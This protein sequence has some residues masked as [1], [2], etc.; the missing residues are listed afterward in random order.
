MSWLVLMVDES[1]SMGIVPKVD[2][3]AIS[4]GGD[5]PLSAIVATAINAWL[6]R[7]AAEFNIALV[8]YHTGEDGEPDIGVRW[9]G[10]LEGSNFV[11]APQ[12]KEA[13]LAIEQRT[14]SLPGAAPQTIDFKVW[15]H[16]AASGSQ[17][18]L[19]AWNWITEF[20]QRECT[21][22]AEVV[23]VNIHAGLSSDGNPVRVIQ[24]FAAAGEERTVILCHMGAANAVPA[25]QYPANPVHLTG[26]A[27]DLFQRCS[28]LKDNLRTPLRAKKLTLNENARGL[29]F[30]GKMSDVSTLLNCIEAA[31]P[32][33]GAPAAPAGGGQAPAPV[34]PVPAPSDNDAAAKEAAEKEAAEKAAAEQA[35]ADRL[36][37]E[38]AEAEKAAAEKAAAEQAE[39]DRIA[40][41]QAEA[42]R[43]AAEQ[44]EAERIAA[45]QAEAERLAAEQANNQPEPADTGGDATG[46]AATGDRSAT[47]IWNR[48]LWS[49]RRTRATR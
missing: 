21:D 22:G 2:P 30:N 12:V 47:R 17:P 44:A 19:A 46:F 49:R 15:T 6:G 42:E 10:S 39:A 29:I 1:E 23:V 36:A 35:E 7:T 5:R 27:R 40:A 37:A 11:A 32:A 24:K 43:L 48:T 31:L 34:A 38:Q 18:Q 4:G 25:T 26:H 3:T 28:V 33:A 8:G 20:V 45:E 41:E 9:A 13:P 14:R 16:G